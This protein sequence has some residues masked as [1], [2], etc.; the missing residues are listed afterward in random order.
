MAHRVVWSLEYGPIPQGLLVLHSCSNRAC[1]NVNH[2][3]LGGPTDVDRTQNFTQAFG[4]EREN[5]MPD[6]SGENIFD[7]LDLEAEARRRGISVTQL[8]MLKATPNSVV[9]D[10]VDDAFRSNPVT[11]Q[12]NPQSG[13]GS[14]PAPGSGWVEPTPLK[15][16][17][18][19]EL[20]DGLVDEQ[21][22][23]DRL[24]LARKLMGK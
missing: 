4:L 17:P 13:K 6:H 18:G 3:R 24:D 22:R 8:R 14:Q 23:R 12:R 5:E 1:C 10:L 9:F 21:D 7:Q 20:I 11:G 15:P 19:I 16:P 2:L